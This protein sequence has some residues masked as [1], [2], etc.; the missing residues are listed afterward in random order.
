MGLPMSA[1]LKK[2]QPL[3]TIKEAAEILNCSVKTV[4]R[5]IDAKRLRVIRDGGLL[6]IEPADLED[7]IRDHR[8]R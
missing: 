2:P 8:S 3:R 1:E 7:Y 6:R 5:R 4:R